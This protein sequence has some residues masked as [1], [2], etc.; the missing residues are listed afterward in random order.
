MIP[1]KIHLQNKKTGAPEFRRHMLK[2]HGVGMD[3]LRSSFSQEADCK[4]FKH[5]EKLPPLPA[6]LTGPKLDLWLVHAF[7]G[8]REH[9]LVDNNDK[10]EAMFTN[11]SL[12]KTI[13]K[14]L[15]ASTSSSQQT[16]VSS[17][18]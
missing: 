18:L 3:N 16:I 1:C 8:L 2:S 4:P 11:P 6:P 7:L 15:R 17:H 14:V 13:W 10:T 9:G 5:L 12:G